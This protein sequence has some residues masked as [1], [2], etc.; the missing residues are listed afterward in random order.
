MGE[1]DAQKGSAWSRKD[2]AGREGACRDLEFFIM[3]IITRK[4]STY[5]G[6]DRS[7]YE[8]LMQAGRMGI[9]M[10]LPKYDPDRSMPTTYFFN[11]IRHEMVL[12]ANLM[13][14]GARDH[15]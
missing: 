8:D 1:K 9:I 14:H 10:A 13:K 2:M 3:N 5:V 4:F 15:T 12:Q 11:A 6:N 7:F